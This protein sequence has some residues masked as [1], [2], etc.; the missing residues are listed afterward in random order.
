[1]DSVLDMNVHNSGSRID[2]CFLCEKRV[3]ISKT[4]RG[5]L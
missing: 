4:H 1:M 5:Y 3:F 2:M